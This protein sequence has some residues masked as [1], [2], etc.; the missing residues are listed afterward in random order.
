MAKAQG[1]RKR[2]AAEDYDSDGGFV[3][4]APKTKKNK[5]GTAKAS[6]NYEMQKD[7]DGNQYWEVGVPCR[8]SL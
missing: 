6:V 2:A 7:T 8:H 3:E 4:D 1:S 5:S